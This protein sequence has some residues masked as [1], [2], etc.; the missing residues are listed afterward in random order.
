MVGM[1][2]TQSGKLKAEMLRS[3]DFWWIGLLR[4]VW[5]EYWDIGDFLRGI[6]IT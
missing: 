3:R 2:K 4:I 1:G 6:E 5:R